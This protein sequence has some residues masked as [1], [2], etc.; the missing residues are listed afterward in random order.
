M[1]DM[2]EVA[3]LPQH[4]QQSYE[5]TKNLMDNPEEL[6]PELQAH[7]VEYEHGLAIKHPLVNEIFYIEPMNPIYNE[8]L[9]KKQE[10]LAKYRAEHEWFAYLNI[11]YERPWRAEALLEVAHEM[12]D[13]EYWEAVGD[14]WTDT[15]NLWQWHELVPE[16]LLNARPR[17]EAMM[18][19][20]ERTWLAALPE[21]VIVFRGH[22]DNNQM[23][24]SWTTDPERAM[25]FAHRFSSLHDYQQVTVGKVKKADI[26]AVFLGR[27]ESEVVADPATV[28]VTGTTEV[29]EDEP[30][31]ECGTPTV[32]AGPDH[33]SFHQQQTILPPPMD[34]DEN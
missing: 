8:R 13:A 6:D 14:V 9:C 23:G 24:W 31:C 32:L 18:D 2:P 16:I 29:S 20:R 19:E 26:I 28:M 10:L 34:E 30:T 5:W 21:E 15:E 12:T 3:D 1:P 33:S 17:R 27:N 7:L 22:E 4:L 11:C 25:W